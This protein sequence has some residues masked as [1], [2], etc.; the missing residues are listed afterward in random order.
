[1]SGKDFGGE[2]RVKTSAGDIIALR[3]NLSIN[4]SGRS[5]EAITQSDGSVDGVHTLTPVTAGVTFADRGNDYKALM[6]GRR[7]WTFIE[8]DTGVTHYFTNAFLSGT[9]EVNRM[10]GEVTGLTLNCASTDYNVTT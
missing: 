2:F 3:G 6:K 1:M 4:S 10:N 7:N 8:E 9:P 5:V